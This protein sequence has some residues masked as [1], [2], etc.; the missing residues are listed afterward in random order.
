M[1][2]TPY[3]LCMP[4]GYS[5]GLAGLWEVVQ[6][7]WGVPFQMR[8]GWNTGLVVVGASEMISLD[9]TAQGIP[10]PGIPDA[11]DG[12]SRGFWVAEARIALPMRPYM[13][14]LGP[15]P[16]KAKPPGGV[17]CTAQPPGRCV[18]RLTRWC[19]WVDSIG[20]RNSELQQLLAAWVQA[21]QG[22]GQWSRWWGGGPG[23]AAWCMSSSSS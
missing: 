7:Q 1:K 14:S 10:E 21:Q 4:P 9:Y 3:V 17:V 18:S 6:R 19:A 2:T 22:H 11:A 20:G 13:A 16:V 5:G 15:M 23:K 8:L 12:H